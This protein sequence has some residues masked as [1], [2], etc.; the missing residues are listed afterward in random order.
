MMKDIVP[1]PLVDIFN[2]E[3]VV[4]R[5]LLMTTLIVVLMAMTLQ[6]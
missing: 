3:I 2:M 6:T 4:M 5:L 1:V